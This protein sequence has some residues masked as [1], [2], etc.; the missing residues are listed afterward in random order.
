[1]FVQSVVLLTSTQGLV[2]AHV[3]RVEYD[4]AGRR[5]GGVV[6]WGGVGGEGGEKK[7]MRQ[8]VRWKSGVGDEKSEPRY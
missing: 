4:T 3:P 8:R 2:V 7:T 1:M 5:G 6:G